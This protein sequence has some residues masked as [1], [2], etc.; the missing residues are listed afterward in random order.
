VAA[1]SDSIGD[2]IE[3]YSYDAFGQPKVH[4][5]PGDD[6]IWMTADDTIAEDWTD[7]KGN[8]LFIHR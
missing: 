8:P 6:G 4:I 1:L 5:G 7:T 3:C 2:I